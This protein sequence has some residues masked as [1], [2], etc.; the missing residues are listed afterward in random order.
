MFPE[1][2][3]HQSGYR[4]FHSA[5]CRWLRVEWPHSEQSATPFAETPSFNVPTFFFDLRASL[6][7]SVAS[8]FRKR[9]CKLCCAGVWLRREVRSNDWQLVMKCSF[10]TSSTTSLHPLHR[11]VHLADT[12]LALLS[13]L[14]SHSSTLAYSADEVSD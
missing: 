12:A 9:Y 2:V 4:A 11:A 14:P 7:R 13:L 5:A 3:R 1:V 6:F 8:L 10:S